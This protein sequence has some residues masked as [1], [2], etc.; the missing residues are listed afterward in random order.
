MPPKLYEMAKIYRARVWLQPSAARYHQQMRAHGGCLRI[1][2]VSESVSLRRCWRGFLAT[3]RPPAEPLLRWQE[4]LE[5]S[6]DLF[7]SL[8][9]LTAS[10]EDRM[11]K[12]AATAALEHK[13]SISPFKIHSTLHPVTLPL[14]GLDAE[15]HSTQAKAIAL[16]LHQSP[17]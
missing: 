17:A 2:R 15:L 16:H 10:S 9:S 7:E 1:Y 5:G 14:T 3:A 8:H 11:Y 13:A 6:W 4:Q 12:S